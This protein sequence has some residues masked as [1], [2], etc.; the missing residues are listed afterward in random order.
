[1][2]NVLYEG[3]EDDLLGDPTFGYYFL[4]IFNEP[5]KVIDKKNDYKYDFNSAIVWGTDPSLPKVPLER[6]LFNS[7]NKVKEV[8]EDLQNEYYQNFVGEE[9]KMKRLERVSKYILRMSLS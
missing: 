7:I 2:Y 5:F 1:M 6:K 8:W 9:Y 4:I 3:S